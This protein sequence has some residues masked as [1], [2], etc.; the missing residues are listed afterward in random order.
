[1]TV[2]LWQTQGVCKDWKMQIDDFE[3]D[4]HLGRCTTEDLRPN[5][6]SAEAALHESW[7]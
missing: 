4:L 3:E 2:A 6:E 5:R 1:M 7:D